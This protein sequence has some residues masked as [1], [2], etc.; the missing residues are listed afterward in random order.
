MREIG[1]MV[2]GFLVETKINHVNNAVKSY[3]LQ[4]RNI[5]IGADFKDYSLVTKLLFISFKA[6]KL[7]IT[8]YYP[9]VTKTST[10]IGLLTSFFV[11]LFNRN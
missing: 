5:K 2:N 7:M 3:N 1:Y 9:S 4:I 8:F 6:V 11:I 10:S